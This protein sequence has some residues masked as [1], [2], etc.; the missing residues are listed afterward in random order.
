VAD[1]SILNGG[2]MDAETVQTSV[3]LIERLRVSLALIGQALM[4]GSLPVAIASDQITMSDRELRQLV[5]QTNLEQLNMRFQLQST[6]AAD[7]VSIVDGRG[8]PGRGS[9]R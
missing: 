6:R 5:E 9:I 1:S 7:R 2:P 8:G 3:G 4:A